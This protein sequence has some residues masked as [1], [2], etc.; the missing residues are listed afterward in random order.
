[1]S[2]LPILSLALNIL[3][4]VPVSGS[5][6][7]KAAWT[8][9]SFGLATP[10][11]SILLSIYLTILLASVT[12]LIHPVPSLIA[13]LLA[14]Q[15]FYKVTTPVTVGTLRNPVVLSN[16]AIAG[17]HAMTLWSLKTPISSI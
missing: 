8:D 11:R 9:T 3:V 15:I 10:A 5:L 6:I 13:G 14:A 16:L 12:L 2:W 7:A 1:M 4:L 17:F